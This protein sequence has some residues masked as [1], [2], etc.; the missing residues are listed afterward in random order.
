MILLFSNLQSISFNVFFLLISI[1]KQSSNPI[2]I[3]SKDIK[4][5]NNGFPKIKKIS[6]SGTKIRSARSINGKNKFKPWN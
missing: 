2:G 6:P 3:T 1:I 5:I 4:P